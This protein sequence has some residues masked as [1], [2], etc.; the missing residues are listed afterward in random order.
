M[1]SDRRSDTLKRK[2]VEVVES[3]FGRIESYSNDQITQ[4]IKTYGNH[5]RPEFAFALGAIDYNMNVFDLGAH[6]GTFSM[7][8]L[9][10]IQRNQRLVS[11]EGSLTTYSIL[12]RNC[13]KRGLAKVDL[14]NG[15]VGESAGFAYSESKENTGSSRL[16]RA[17]KGQKTIDFMSI[18]QLVAKYFVPDYIKIDIE[19]AEF[20]AFKN[21]KALRQHKPI[22]YMEMS[23]A[24]LAEF[25]HSISMMNELMK[26]I[27]YSFFV[28]IGDRNARRDFFR[29]KEIEALDKYKPFF[30][31]LCIPTNSNLLTSL[32]R[33]SQAL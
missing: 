9:Q 13:A 3:Q 30:D 26:D 16:V 17:L 22:I 10:K 2:S 1:N 29:V 18:D 24:Q 25:G 20:D 6:I 27:G 33:I 12:K 31:V 19:G 4:Q 7:A 23:S 32:R 15:F 14:V 8:V 28:N 21:C 11:V 5:T